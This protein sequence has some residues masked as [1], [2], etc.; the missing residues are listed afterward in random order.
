ML[1]GEEPQRRE[2][3]RTYDA[4]ALPAKPRGRSVEDDVYGDNNSGW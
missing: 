2:Q 4:E 1:R 3:G